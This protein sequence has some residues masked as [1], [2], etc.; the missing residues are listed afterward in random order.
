MEAQTATDDPLLRP[1]LLSAW[2]LHSLNLLAD[3]HTSRIYRVQRDDG[4]GAV[5]KL[6]KPEGRHERAGFAYLA[7]RNGL[8]AVRVLEQDNEACLLEDA[9]AESLANL[10]KSEGDRAATPILCQ[11]LPLLHAPSPQPPP[12]DLVSLEQHFHSLFE[13]AEQAGPHREMACW[14]AAEARELLSRQTRSIP[15]HGDLHH[16]NVFKGKDGVW[17]VI[18]PQGLIGDPAYEVANIF[19]NPGGSHLFASERVAR[20][21]DDFAPMLECSP[22]TV[23]RFAG[24]HAML[25]IAW[26]L[27][28]PETPETVENIRERTTVARHLRS[29]I[30]QQ[31]V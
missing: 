15:L 19:G 10:H 31:S 26:S 30:E 24:V 5:I 12:A 3:T 16:D 18:D 27:H 25:S 22:L 2:R 21:A 20:L 28:R 17:R 29:L 6:L 13:L 23:L 14:A 1:D 4:K 11:L 9:G 8:G 7:W